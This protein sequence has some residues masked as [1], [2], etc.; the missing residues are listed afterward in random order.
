MGEHHCVGPNSAVRVPSLSLKGVQGNRAS[1][2]LLPTLQGETGNPRVLESVRCEPRYK[3]S[4]GCCLCDITIVRALHT[5]GADVRMRRTSDAD[6]AGDSPG[7]DP[8]ANRAPVNDGKH[9]VRIHCIIRAS[10]SDS[11]ARRCLRCRCSA[12]TPGCCSTQPW[13]PLMALACQ[14]T[15]KQGCKACRTGP[16]P[17]VERLFQA[18]QILTGLK[19]HRFCRR[20]CKGCSFAQLL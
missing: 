6:Q 7:T 5:G 11:V 4:G 10:T 9:C 1:Y 15:L 13:S 8:A 12:A 14:S 17:P 20:K 2:N 19:T 3:Q 16:R 18:W